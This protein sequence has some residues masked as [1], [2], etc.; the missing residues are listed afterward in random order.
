MNFIFHSVGNVIIPTVTHSYFS[1]GL[2][3]HLSC[4]G[5][6]VV[7]FSI[8]RR[9]G[10]LISF[11]KWRWNMVKHQGHWMELKRMGAPSASWWNRG[12][13]TIQHSE[14][15]GRNEMLSQASEVEKLFFWVFCCSQML[16]SRPRVFSPSKNG[17]TMRL[18]F[19]LWLTSSSFLHIFGAQIWKHHI[20]WNNLKHQLNWRI[21]EKKSVSQEWEQ[22]PKTIGF[23][24]KMTKWRPIIGECSSSK[25]SLRSRCARTC[26]RK[27]SGKPQG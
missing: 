9:V 20:Y 1:E 24:L 15:P 22:T 6:W 18:W 10:G 3:Y 5:D 12:C 14:R 4:N 23:P 26:C 25:H 19:Q 16:F 2:F 7:I 8:W 17:A 11:E 13:F 27:P 21:G